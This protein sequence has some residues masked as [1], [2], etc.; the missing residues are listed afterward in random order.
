M[1]VVNEL[2]IKAHIQKGSKR[3]A[4]HQIKKNKKIKVVVALAIVAIRWSKG[5]LKLRFKHIRVKGV[6]TKSDEE[7]HTMI[8]TK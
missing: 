7:V 4:I 1:G 3:F 6:L 8:S 5:D 2:P